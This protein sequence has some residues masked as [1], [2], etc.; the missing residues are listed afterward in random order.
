MNQT[1]FEPT[2]AS[3]AALYARN[4][5][6]PIVMLNLL[7]FRETADYSANPDQTPATPI[8][9]REAYQKYMDHTTPFLA[10]SGGELVLSGTGGAFFIGP[11]DDQWD[12]VLLVRHKSL[13][14][15]MAFATNEA[16]LA[17]MAHRTAALADTRLL[18]VEPI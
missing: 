11:S 16:Y 5:T 1:Y 10:E 15:F 14:A 13:A 3:G 4:I 18:P 9:G 7:R 8:S 2:Q 12:M 6:G 17:G